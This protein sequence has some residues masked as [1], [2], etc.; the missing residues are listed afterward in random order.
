MRTSIDFASPALLS[1]LKQFF[2]LLIPIFVHFAHTVEI[3]TGNS[4]AVACGRIS[5]LHGLQ[6]PCVSVDTA[7]SSSLV[8]THLLRESLSGSKSQADAGLA[9][10]V[11]L[12]LRRE[13]S[14]FS[15]RSRAIRSTPDTCS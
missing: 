2:A 6:G 13:T 9:T 1:P 12:A 14:A 10:A 11:N 3:P 15:L 5:F 4:H 8:A 7:C